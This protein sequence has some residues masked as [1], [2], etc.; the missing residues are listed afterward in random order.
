VSIDN[1][2]SGYW[3][4]SSLFVAE[5][6]EDEE[7]NP[8]FYGRQPANWLRQ[9]FIK[10]GY[11]VEEIIPEDWGWCVMCQR[12]PYCLWVGCVNLRDYKYAKEGDPPPTQDRLL[13]NAA[14]MA[15]VPFFKYLFR[16]KPNVS[17]GL[18]KFDSELRAI[19]EAEP[20]IQL[21]D[22]SVA[23]RWFQ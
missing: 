13:W 14:P 3:F 23:D 4:T 2:Y 1:T 21:V 6:G 8:R 9:R 19:L 11:P 22:D 10:R 12:D 18:A 17:E 5:P 16:R 20:C 7:T 15:E